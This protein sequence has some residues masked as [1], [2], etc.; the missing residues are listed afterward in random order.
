V[1]EI[2]YFVTYGTWRPELQGADVIK[3]AMAEW[4]K[5]VEENGLKVQLWGAPYGTSENAICVMK[6]T[7]EDYT[8]LAA[9]NSPYSASRTNMVLVW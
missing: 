4:S 8:K 6:G 2:K 3:K 9:L 1:A 7:V 5:T